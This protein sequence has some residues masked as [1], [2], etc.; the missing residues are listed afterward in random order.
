MVAADFTYVD[1]NT[2][3]PNAFAAF[4]SSDTCATGD[5]FFEATANGTGFATGD[6]NVDKVQAASNAIYDGAGNAMSTSRQQVIAEATAPYVLSA[7]SYYSGGKSYLRIFFSEAV[8][9]ASASTSWSALRAANYT[10][11]YSSGTACPSFLATT[12]GGVTAIGGSN[13]VFDLQTDAQCT[14]TVFKVTALTTIKDIDEFENVSTPNF[15]YTY[16]TV[17]VGETTAPRLLLARS[18]SAT[19]VELTYSEPMK[20]G[21]QLGSAE[22]KS[23]YT[24][25]ATCSADIDGTAG[26]QVKYWITPTLGN[27]TAA[28]A[29][30]D[31]SVYIVTHAGT[32]SGNFYTIN[33]Y[34]SNSVTN[35]PNDIA[36]N[37]LT[38]NQ[39]VF[40]GAGTPILNF[41]DGAVFS[42]P[43]SDGT[44]F[45]YA[46]T[47][48]SKVY[49]GPNDKNNAAFRFEADGLNPVGVTF[50]SASGSTCAGA[51]SFGITGGTCGAQT[52]G[53]NGENGIVAFNS[54][55]LT[56]GASNYEILM[57]GPIRSAGVG[58]F[59]Y[60][61]DVDTQLD[62]SGCS[63]SVQ[64]GANIQSIQ[65]SYVWGDSMYTGFTIDHGVQTPQ[66]N[67]FQ[68]TGSPGTCGAA[69]NS[70]LSGVNYIGHGSGNKRKPAS[71]T[72]GPT[73]A[74]VDS[75]LYI[76]T[77][78]SITPT[79]TFFIGS[80]GGIAATTGT[81]GTFS[82]VICQKYGTGNSSS[83]LCNTAGEP[84][85]PGTWTGTKY[86]RVVNKLEKIR[87]GE[88]AIPYMIVY[89]NAI[90]MVRNLAVDYA[91]STNSVT[92]AGG[93]I[94]KCTTNCATPTSSA[95]NWTKVLDIQT[96]LAGGTNNKAISVLQVNGNVLY[97]GVDNPTDG[98]RM[99]RTTVAS[100]TGGSDF[101][102]QG[103][104]GLGNTA[105]NQYFFSSASIRKGAS[106]YIYV[107]VGDANLVAIKVLR[108]VD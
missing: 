79:N 106:N 25:A 30:A 56:V 73:I 65:S 12:P 47:Y 41:S 61:F 89:K 62:F 43:F 6:L 23:T 85:A 45:N 38:V 55:T 9:N 86:T 40:Q 8:S 105:E 83:E 88:K 74:S 5:A 42:D 80:A 104:A 75:M 50:Y 19:T 36:G 67:R 35:I 24:T 72:V 63:I 4:S 28:A 54:G 49:L 15:A 21:D 68:F 58:N 78:S 17:S 103:S 20:S 81:P 91:N 16:G 77:G 92:S 98:V 90:Y 18:L 1:G 26:T 11:E 95:T 39:A 29:T 46:F 33:A 84:Q 97:L 93:E 59:Y 57:L 22:C 100:V 10:V 37:R 32:Q 31:P 27:V 99:F 53:P 71:S 13:R 14:G 34:A 48:Q 7:S 108:Q 64:G 94:Y 51:T 107:T 82:T 96:D 76:P 3:A 66:L 101:A 69:A 102:L 87:P 70:N 44:K 2:A 60:T 52:I